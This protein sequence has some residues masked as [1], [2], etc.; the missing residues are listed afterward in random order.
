MMEEKREGTLN[1][2]HIII[3]LSWKFLSL[4]FNFNFLS[5]YWKRKDDDWR[6]L[7][8][9]MRLEIAYC[10]KRIKKMGKNTKPNKKKCDDDRA[11]F[12]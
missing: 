10:Q 1:R 12:N 2:H 9:R 11:T 3:I 5:E 6:D 8:R 7:D 4:N